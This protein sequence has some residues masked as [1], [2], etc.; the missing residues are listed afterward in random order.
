MVDCR[1]WLRGKLST[2]I[3]SNPLLFALEFSFPIQPVIARYYSAEE[4]HLFTSV[5]VTHSPYLVCPFLSE[6]RPLPFYQVLL[7]SLK[8][9]PLNPQ[10]EKII[11]NVES[12]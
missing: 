6:A 8:P 2:I 10:G 9:P 3:Y 12:I 5:T 7:V 11:I 4:R 1:Q